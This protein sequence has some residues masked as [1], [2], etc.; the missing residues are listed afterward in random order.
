MA[1]TK[2]GRPPHPAIA[3]LARAA[4]TG[5]MDR[6]EFLTLATAL[7]LSGPAAHMALG[8]PAPARAQEAPPLPAPG[9]LR[10]QMRVF[11]VDDPRLFD[12]SEKG[13][14]ARGLLE[15]LVRYTA[16]FTLEPWLLSDWEVSD[17]ARHY[18][19]RLRPDVTWSNGDPFTA[20]D[21]VANLR[22]W[23]DTTVPGNSMTNRM[24]SLI[25]PA[26][27]QAR[28]GAIASPDPL[29]VELTLVDPDVTLIPGMADYPAL[30]VHRDFDAQGAN[31]ALNP[32]GTGPYTLDA[33]LPG[34]GAVLV[35]RDGWW[36]G[37]V[38]V[39]RIEYVDLGTDPS[40]FARAVVE[41]RID[42]IHD[43]TG[44]FVQMFD[45]LGL[46]RQDVLSGATL[47]CRTNRRTAP[48]Y[49]DARVRRALQLAVDNAVILELGYADLGAVGENHHVAPMNPDYADIG[50]P[51][52]DPDAALALIR[53]A[54]LEEYEHELVSIDDDWNR[55]SADAIAAQLRDAGI[56]VRRTILHGDDF[57]SSWQSHGFSC[58]G[59]NM[60]PLGVQTLALGYA[61]TGM[62]N[63][64]GFADPHF[65][66]LLRLAL[67]LV[68]PDARRAV[69]AELEGIL[70][71]DGTIIQPYWRQLAWHHTERVTGVRRHPMDEHHHDQWGLVP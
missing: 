21:V 67:G 7:G 68:D 37:E 17:D 15:N 22:R 24:A 57:W 11:P 31:I 8:L 5:R 46:I 66:Q 18:V 30:I 34:E 14:I 54:G 33:I 40:D 52:P 4:R 2:D 47:V 23:C 32:V 39:E 50:R 16:D 60:R 55:A 64:T 49:A 44:A 20:E 65:D 69:M 43:S 29:T 38:A 62:W 13:N 27:G 51:E 48:V 3:P 56:Q 28:E 26:T 41:A 53:E 12:W 71:A 61:S 58:T 63:E 45:D 35:R 70:V 6:R 19:L 36:G 1:G 9:I 59:W 10:C 42:M 25:D